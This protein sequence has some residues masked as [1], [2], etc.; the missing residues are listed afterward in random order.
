MDLREFFSEHKKTA[1]AF[2]GGADSAYLL[3]AAK[4]YGADVRPYL[5]KSQ[6]QPDFEL[7]DAKLLASI[8]GA[9]LSVI[10]LDVLAEPSIRNNSTMRC[11]YCKKRILSAIK[12]R[13]FEDGYF[14]IMDGTNASDSFNERPGMKALQEE[15]ILSP[16]RLCGI[17]KA[18]LRRLSKEAGLFTWDK[19]AYACLATRIPEGSEI[20]EKALFKTEKSEELLK[21]L[22][23]SDFRLRCLGDTGK[24][25]VK[26][27]QMQFVIDN[28]LKIRELLSDYYKD[29]VLDLKAR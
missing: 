18:Q 6:F 21:N 24:L 27:A 11:Y 3:Y 16:L 23:L 22:G 9:E 17:Q 25:Q 19:P 8:L 14:E 12:A 15:G 28:R 5:V 4:L 13:A 26:E 10:E 20:T 7:E 29:I 2:S 1:L